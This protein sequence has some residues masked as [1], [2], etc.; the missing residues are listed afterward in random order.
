MRTFRTVAAVRPGAA[1][2]LAG[3]VL[4]G[5]AVLAG[6]GPAGSP[7]ASMS[8]APSGLPSGL[9]SGSPTSTGDKPPPPSQSPSTNPGRSPGQGQGRTPSRNPGNATKTLVRVTRTGGFAGQTHTVVVKGDGSW[10]RLDV[11]A[12][13]A[14]TGKMSPQELDALNAALAKADFAHLPRVSTG[15]PVIYDGYTYA[16]VHDGF[17]VASD[18]G[19]MPPALEAVLAALPPFTG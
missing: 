16:F 6:C 10:T 2:R 17:E 9:P 11:K 14:G 18:Q 19:S 4:L 1:V 3:A 13:P 8:R 12:Q 7:D 5:A 15:G